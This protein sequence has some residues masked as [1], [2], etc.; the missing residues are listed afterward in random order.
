MDKL[1]VKVLDLIKKIDERELDYIDI[2]MKN[3]IYLWQKDL[4]MNYEEIAKKLEKQKDFRRRYKLMTKFVDI[5]GNFPLSNS[6]AIR[7]NHLRRNLPNFRKKYEWN[8]NIWLPNE[9][10]R[11]EKLV[12]VH[13]FKSVLEVKV[14]LGIHDFR[15]NHQDSQDVYDEDVSSKMME[16]NK[17]L[18]NLSQKD[19]NFNVDEYWTEFWNLV[20]LDLGNRCERT[21]RDCQITWYHFIDPNINR[22]PWEKAE[23]LRLLALV[24]ENEGFNW[25]KVA[26]ELNTGRTP[27]QCIL[28]YQ[29]SLNKNLI[30]SS[31][32]KE[33][34]EKL[35]S[36]VK[37]L[38]G[39]DL[40][41]LNKRITSKWNLVAN[42]LPGRTNQ[43]CRTRYVRSLKKDLKHGSW[44]LY[45][46]VRL[47]FAYFVYGSNS[48]TKISRHIKGRSDSKCR[49]RYMNMLL[50]DIKKGKWT[51]EENKMLI[52]A[53][54]RFGPGNWSLI[55][56]FVIGRTD[57]DCSKQWEKLD[58]ASSYQYDII[59][60]TQKHMLPLSYKWIGLSRSNH[61]L[62]NTIQK[63]SQGFKKDEFIQPKLSGSDFFVKPAQN[64]LSIAQY[65]LSIYN[66]KFNS[67]NGL[68]NFSI[69]QLIHQLEQNRTNDQLVDQI[70][71]KIQRSL[72]NLIKRRY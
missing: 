8:N 37:S 65:V 22:K 35:L 19:T 61:K 3:E 29:R 56:N 2:L 9:I 17:L 41:E 5:E 63:Q 4:V 54:N 38:G 67:Q 39:F 51:E 14:K 30:K 21:G 66:D 12:K 64:I 45:E 49:E 23:D 52:L 1:Y 7:K 18:L 57:A 10:K 34:D 11:L 36:A 50:P 69:D 44:S 59:R 26:Q 32:T 58:P 71:L 25:I 46:D 31:W 20:S 43:Q 24:S 16:L 60:A 47:Q 42:L 62:L 48:W 28:R 55:K 40:L 70:L 15:F 33:E 13:L 68:S 27:Y 6:D 53:V 72:I